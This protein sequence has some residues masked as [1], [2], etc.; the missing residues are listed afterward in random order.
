[1][2][3]SL[4]MLTPLIINYI[5][6]EH[7]QKVF[8][9]SFL[10]TF[11]FG[12][13]LWFLN[14]KSSKRL[15]T[16]DGFIIVTSIWVCVSIFGC[17]PYILAPDL[18]LSLSKAVF[19]STSGFTTTGATIISHLDDLSH[20][21]LFYRQQTE[22]LGGMGIIVLTVAI[23]PL[24]GVG[25]IKLYNAETSSPWKDEKISPKI[26][27]TAKALWGIYLLLTFLCFISYLLAGLDVFNA[28]CYTLSTVST[29]GFAPCDASMSN[30]PT[31]VIIVCIVFLFLSAIGFKLHYLA[32]TKFRLKYYIQDLEFRTYFYYLFFI[33]FIISITL[34]ANS[35][36][37]F[38][39]IRI[40]LDSI[41]Q[42]VSLSSSAGFISNSNY[43]LWPSFLPILLILVLTIGGCAGSTSGGLKIIR[44][45]LFT[46]KAT[47]EAKKVINPQGFFTIKIGDIHISES[48]LNKVSGFISIYIIFFCIGW[49]SLLGT[50]L[51][52][53]TSFSAILTSLSNA[54]PGLGDI[55]SSFAKVSN[56][57]LWICSFFMIAGR[58]EI[59]TIVVL[60]IPE[61]W[62][63]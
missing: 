11:L 1:M 47:L 56:S 61:F 28:L 19:E 4:T 57:S 59:F 24:L 39:V 21:I 53:E 20:S 63:K 51:N 10:I 52:I 45:I 55:G 34:I 12:F 3:L 13:L 43:Y 42:T 26:S 16:N 58:L 31:S 37:N 8:F 15:K 36:D 27:S 9:Y 32:L 7:N 48:A 50:G 49:L 25:G 33:S 23:L 41:F 17:I 6:N 22:F 18:N 2:L 46:K 62:R 40:V 38:D 35:K 14:R 5:Y 54:G 44:A 30:M 29:G 60:L